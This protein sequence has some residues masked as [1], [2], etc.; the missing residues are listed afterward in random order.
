MKGL[1]KDTYT[2]VRFTV[3]R[4]RLEPRLCYQ[5]VS[6]ADICLVSDMLSPAEGTPHIPL[7]CHAV[8]QESEEHHVT[9]IVSEMEKDVAL[10]GD[11][12][13]SEQLRM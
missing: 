6:N 4:V 7:L 9:Q 12:P 3:T 8:N 13:L 10:M 1:R 5:D 2:M 11:N